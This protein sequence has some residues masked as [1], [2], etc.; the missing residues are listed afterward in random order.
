MPRPL[1]ETLD[2]VDDAPI[3]TRRHTLILALIFLVVAAAG[4]YSRGRTGLTAT[5]ARGS[6][7]PAVYVPVIVAEL[8]LI[9]YVWSGTRRRIDSPIAT[10]VGRGW[11][12]VGAIAFD[13]A[14]AAAMWG[15]WMMLEHIGSRLL[16]AAHGAPRSLLPVG[17][18]DQSLWIALSITAGAAEEIV[19][20]GYFLRQIAALAGR[21]WVGL[22][23]QAALF[24]VAHGYEG[25]AACVKVAVFGMLFG[26]VALWRRN[27]R[28]CIIAHA[29]TD[30]AA[31]LL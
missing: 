17:T 24:S 18:L 22:V 15:A 19:F 1:V 8:A 27:L 3:A 14:L 16:P 29:W 28:A 20:R 12:G 11:D 23:A 6:T 4:A 26:L 31:G 21:R 25:V 30:I 7:G 13:V 5:S 10:L 2:A 9:Y